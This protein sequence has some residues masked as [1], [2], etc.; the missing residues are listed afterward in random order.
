M[1]KSIELLLA[2]PLKHRLIISSFNFANRSFKYK[3]NFNQ[4][5]K[6]TAN[7]EIERFMTW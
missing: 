1:K 6:Q 7:P 4:A 2:T 5:S 3:L